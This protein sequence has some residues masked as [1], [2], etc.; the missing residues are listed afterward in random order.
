[1]NINLNTILAGALAGFAGAAKTDLAV[2]FARPEKLAKFNWRLAGTRY[3]VGAVTGA[4]A[5]LGVG[6]TGALG[7]SPVGPN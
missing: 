5:V 3:A 2:F 6:A 7:A 1:M 4:L